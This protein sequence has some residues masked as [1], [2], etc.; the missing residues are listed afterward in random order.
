MGAELV[1]GDD[2][3]GDY[4]QGQFLILIPVHGD[5][6]I[7][8]FNFQGEE[9]GGGIWHSAVGEALGCRQTGAVGCGDTGEFKFVSLNRDTD[10]M[11]LSLLGPDNGHRRE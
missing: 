1:L 8:N 5:I 10:L 6:V 9:Y 11:D 4:G 7:E 2:I 3:F